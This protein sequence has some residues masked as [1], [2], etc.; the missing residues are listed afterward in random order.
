[1]SALVP[2]GP[3][4]TDGNSVIAECIRRGSCRS[5]GSGVTPSGRAARDA[6]AAVR[7]QRI[8]A[9]KGRRFL[10][11]SSSEGGNEL[12]HAA[13]SVVRSAVQSPLFRV[14]ASSA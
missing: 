12:Y 11:G 6:A 2:P 9:E 1:M 3:T 4:L 5:F 13:A 8:A 7:R 14:A 10:I